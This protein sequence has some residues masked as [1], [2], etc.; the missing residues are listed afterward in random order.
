MN[1]NRKFAAVCAGLWFFFAVFAAACTSGK[2]QTGL[3][4][5]SLTITTASGKQVEIKA[6]IARTPEQR[7]KGLMFR[8]ELPDG[9]GML[10]VFES[11]EP[12]SFW[13]KNTLIDLSIAFINSSGTILEIKNMYAGDLSSVPSSYP[14]RY[15]LEAPRGWFSRAGIAAGDKISPV[16]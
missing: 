10:F 8:K 4:A 1:S 9:K 11:E 13:M 7:Q 5:R 3:E 16:D 15:A 6:E 12:L 14:V 2:A